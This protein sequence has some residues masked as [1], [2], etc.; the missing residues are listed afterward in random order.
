MRGVRWTAPDPC[1]HPC[2]LG[3]YMGFPTRHRTCN[4][5]SKLCPSLYESVPIGAIDV[6]MGA[7]TTESCTETDPIPANARAH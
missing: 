6:P 3:P 2:S 1:M 7:E 4:I 5:A